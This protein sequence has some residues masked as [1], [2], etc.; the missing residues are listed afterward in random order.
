MT[1]MVTV[2]NHKG[3]VGKSTTAV[4]IGH[5]LA[6]AGYRVLLIDLD[7]QGHSA[8]CLGLPKEPR[9]A[10]LLMGQ[11]K[12]ADAIMPARSSFDII[13]GDASTE[14]AKRFVVAGGFSEQVFV[15]LLEDHTLRRYDVIVFDT[16][17]SLDVLHLAA[18]MA[19]D[20]LLI[21][22]KLD[23]LALDGVK[24]V[25]STKQRIERHR[26]AIFAF[27]ILP[28]FFERR[29]TETLRQYRVLEEHFGDLTWPPIPQDTYVR[30]SAN[31]GQTLWEGPHTRALFGYEFS[32]VRV[33]GY[34]QALSHLL[35]LLH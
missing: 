35:R 21:P 11:I 2:A 16:A 17:P 14:A 30:T 28:T 34:A 3:G 4:N 6:L 23:A 20:F 33:G 13:P 10:Q 26:A 25:L 9:L 7:T 5:G 27:A 18:L 15:D 24:G 12:V 31:L 8:V 19:T 29:T 1:I 22:T 32:G